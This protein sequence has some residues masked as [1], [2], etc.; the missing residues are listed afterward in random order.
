V[1][2]KVTGT[3]QVLYEGTTLLNSDKGIDNMFDFFAEPIVRHRDF[4]IQ[5]GVG[6]FSDLTV[7]ITLT[8]S[9]EVVKCGTSIIGV[10]RKIG[11]TQ[12]GASVGI[13]D[14]SIKTTDAFG[15]YIILERAFSKTASYSFWLKPDYVTELQNILADYRATAVL[16]LGTDEYRATWIYGFYRTFEIVFQTPTQAFCSVN[17]EGLT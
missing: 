11:Y 14:F 3:G 4:V 1:Q 15:N 6:L 16:Y 8:A 7:T 10:Y 12:Y 2:I 5:T 17:L 13:N 9:N